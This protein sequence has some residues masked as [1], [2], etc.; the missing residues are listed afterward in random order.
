MI[1]KGLF[2]YFFMKTYVVDKLTFCKMHPLF[3][4]YN[5]NIMLCFYEDVLRRQKPS[6][7]LAIFESGV[8][9]QF[10]SFVRSED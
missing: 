2:S 1:I 3:A 6:V 7:H 5:A 10:M 4:L 9:V 8:V